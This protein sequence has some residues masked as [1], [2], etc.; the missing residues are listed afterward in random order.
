MTVLDVVCFSIKMIGDDNLYK[1]LVGEGEENQSYKSDKDLILIA[2]NQAIQTASCYYPLEYTETLSAVDGRIKYSSFTHNPYKIIEIKG[3][4]RAKINP[5]EI[6]TNGKLTVTY[7]YVPSANDL[8]EDFIFLST[9]ISAVTIAFGVLSEF[10]IYKGRFEEASMYVDKFINAL[11]NFKI[12][13]SNM[14]IKARE[15]F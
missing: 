5:T 11:K 13:S 12:A 8:S 10:L 15:W 14:R 6:L 3:D 9:P 1:Y 7:Y 2:Y 4:K